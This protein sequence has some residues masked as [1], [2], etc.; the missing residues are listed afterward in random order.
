[1]AAAHQL[2]MSATLQPE[3][4]LGA[5][6]IKRPTVKNDGARAILDV[7]DWQL[8]T[9]VD[10]GRVRGVVDVR[11]R[12]AERRDLRFSV[13]A[14][15]EFKRAVPAAGSG[16]VASPARTDEQLAELIFGKPQPLIRARWIY[17]A[18]NCKPSHFYD[19]VSEKVIR[20]ARGSEQRCGPGGSAVAEWNELG[21]FI[22]ER[23]V[24]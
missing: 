3:L 21:R 22:R 1:M 8:A 14:L 19:L 15:E 4:S 16:A 24:A 10:A 5:A 6:R 11:S 13:V 18:L 23:R 9:I 2:I 12:S 7:E 20:L 17:R